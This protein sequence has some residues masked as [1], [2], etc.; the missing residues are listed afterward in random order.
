MGLKSKIQEDKKK[1]KSK[2]HDIKLKRVKDLSLCGDTRD[3][4][5]IVYEK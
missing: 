1:K 2:S 4:D 5:L 3:T